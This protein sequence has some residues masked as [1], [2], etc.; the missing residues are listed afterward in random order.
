MLPIGKARRVREGDDLAILA[1]GDRVAPALQDA[2]MLAEDGLEARVVDMRWT[3]PLDEGEIAEAAK[4]GLV[5]TVES[6][7]VLGGAGE[8]VLE[9][10]SRLGLQVP[11]RVLG[12]GDAFVPHGSV[13]ELMAELGL[14]A[15][16]IARAAKG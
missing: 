9:V 10:L 8:G 11:T 12:I 4:T 5:V 16:G 14:D 1:F 6:G 3:K 7:C 2:E 15:Q 13:A